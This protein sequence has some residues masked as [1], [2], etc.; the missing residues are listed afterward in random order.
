MYLQIISV[1]A[2]VLGVLMSVSWF[3][4]AHKIWKRKSSEDVSLLLLVI[5]SLG[6]LAFLL[7]GIALKQI[8]VILSFAVG[9]VGAGLVLFFAVKYRKEKRRKGKA[10][11]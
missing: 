11:K 10:R 7:Y 4:Q 2:T 6:N 8:P 3:I 5:F 1:I 9:L